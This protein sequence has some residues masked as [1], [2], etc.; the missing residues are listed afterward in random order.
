MKKKEEN[1]PF[2]SPRW[3]DTSL[4]R[5]VGYQELTEEEKARAEEWA[6]MIREKYGKP[7]EK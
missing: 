3:N 4:P 6:K 7:E 5:V 1:K 2:S